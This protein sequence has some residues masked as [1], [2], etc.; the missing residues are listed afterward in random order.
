METDSVLTGRIR[1]ELTSVAWEEELFCVLVCDETFSQRQP[2][3]ARHYVKGQLLGARREQLV[4]FP[5]LPGSPPPAPPGTPRLLHTR[6]VSAPG[7][8]SHAQWGLSRVAPSL[9]EPTRGQWGCQ[10]P[11]LLHGASGGL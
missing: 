7:L 1:D 3:R 10:S 8:D 6:S 5:S 4:C 11:P 9:A 2:T